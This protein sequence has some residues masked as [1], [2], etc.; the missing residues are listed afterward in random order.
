MY[1]KA[2]SLSAIAIAASAFA[3][4]AEMTENSYSAE[5]TTIYATRADGS[6]Y[7]QKDEECKGQFGQFIGKTIT[8]V[9]K[10]DVEKNEGGGELSF[11]EQQ[12]MLQ[13]VKVGDVWGFVTT[14]VPDPLVEQRIKKINVMPLEGTTDARAEVELEPTPSEFKCIAANHDRDN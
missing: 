2:I 6:E 4:N 5:L 7:H 12:M 3:A 8:G 9:Y 11:D 13:P 14:E 1:T 10:I